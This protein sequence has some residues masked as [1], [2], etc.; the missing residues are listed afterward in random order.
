MNASTVSCHIRY[1]V[2]SYIHCPH[3]GIETASQD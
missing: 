3:N 2:P 1:A